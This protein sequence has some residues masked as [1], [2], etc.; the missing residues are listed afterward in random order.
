MHATLLADG[1]GHIPEDSVSEALE[2]LA[3]PAWGNL[4]AIADS[5]RVTALEDFY[6]RRM[7]YQSLPRG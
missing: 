3:N 1:H 7:L 5:S 6:R 4:L 2:R